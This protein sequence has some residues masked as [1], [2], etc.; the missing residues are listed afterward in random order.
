MTNLNTVLHISDNERWSKALKN[1]ENYLKDIGENNAII[2]VVANSDAVKAYKAQDLIQ[3]MKALHYRG[4]TFIACR[5]ALA[6]NS[7][8]TSSLPNF[9]K[10]VP[11]AITH[12]V[13]KQTEGYAYIKP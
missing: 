4:I 3:E 1:I 13:L 7:I 6:A 10:I 12:L 2:E 11:G 9:I 5:N 8:D